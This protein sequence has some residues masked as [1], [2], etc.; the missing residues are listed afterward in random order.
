MSAECQTERRRV[1]YRYEEIDVTLSP[2]DVEILPT[3]RDGE[4]PTA[5]QPPKIVMVKDG[6]WRR[7]FGP[8]V[9]AKQRG[10]DW[11]MGVFLPIVCFW[12][13]PIVFRAPEGPHGTL[14]GKF[15]V[16]AYLLAIVSMVA[17]TGWLTFGDKLKWLNGM[18]AGLFF[19]GSIISLVLGLLI[20]PYSVIGMLFL[21]GFLG[22]APLLSAITYS[23]NAVRA[24]RASEPFFEARTL[25]Y[26]A[27]LTGIFSIVLPW[28]ANQA[29]K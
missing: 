25:K 19:A 4:E 11:I 1:F 12:L 21:I 17:M 7:Q 20:F 18:F 8:K 10:F 23:R 15:S 14:L 9:T 28:L 24:M 27:M 22:L 13:D 2:D 16:F 5:D 3:E 6:F 29:G 26:V